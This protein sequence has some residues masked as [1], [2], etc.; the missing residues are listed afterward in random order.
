MV[1]VN[2]LPDK[3]SGAE[4]A[5]GTPAE[6]EL[7][8]LGTFRLTMNGRVVVLHEREQ[9]VLALL[10]IRDR[11]MTRSALAGFLWPEARM[12]GRSGV[13]AQ[14]SVDYPPISADN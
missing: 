10:A 8:L 2:H 13:C 5:S 7:A 14:R 4:D 6:F 9:R 1:A 3:D 11:T 12:L